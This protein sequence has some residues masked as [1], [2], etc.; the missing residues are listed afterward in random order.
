MIDVCLLVEGAY[1]Y[2][3]GGVS[4]WLHALITHLPDLTFALVYIGPCPDPQ[5]K[6]LYTL[7]ENV[8]E[9]HEVFINDMQRVKV[10]ARHTYQSGAWPALQKLHDAMAAGKPHEVEGFLSLFREPG[11]AGLTAA[12][13]FYAR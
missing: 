4:S 13:L 5:R 3:T 2:V 8:A 11:F 10:P 9:F 7:P 12:D 1:P 6:V